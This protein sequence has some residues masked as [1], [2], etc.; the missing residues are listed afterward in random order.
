MAVVEATQHR[1]DLR[2]R[3]TERAEEL[4]AL[5]DRHMVELKERPE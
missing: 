5:Y 3:Q 4:K 2:A 1:S